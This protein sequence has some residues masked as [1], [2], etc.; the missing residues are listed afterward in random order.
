[1]ESRGL[2]EFRHRDGTKVVDAYE[3]FSTQH[4][5]RGDHLEFDGAQWALRDRLD[6]D[7]VA[8]YV[9]TEIGEAELMVERALR[10]RLI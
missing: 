6:R 10:R 5:V 2:I 7:G 8:V 4:L 3:K 1:M 9:F